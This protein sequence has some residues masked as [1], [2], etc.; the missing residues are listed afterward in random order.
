MSWGWCIMLDK[1]TGYVRLRVCVLPV[2]KIVSPTKLLLMKI[3]YNFQRTWHSPLLFNLALLYLAPILSYL[4]PILLIMKNL[5]AKFLSFFILLPFLFCYF[6]LSPNF[7]FHILTRY[8]FC[9]VS[10]FFKITYSVFVDLTLVIHIFFEAFVS[11]ASLFYNNVFTTF[12]VGIP[13]CLF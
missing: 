4:D 7:H 8:L 6:F 3:T 5:A 9:F 2:F 11:G 10:Y 1:P 12:K 13:V